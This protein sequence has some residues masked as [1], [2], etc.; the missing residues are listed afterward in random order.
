MWVLGAF[1]GLIGGMLLEDAGAI[2]GLISIGI[3]LI[4]GEELNNIFNLIPPSCK[5]LE[6]ENIRNILFDPEKLDKTLKACDSLKK[7]SREI[8]ERKEKEEKRKKEEE[9]K[10]KKEEEE[11]RKREEEEKRKKE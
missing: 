10:R 11:K 3:L 5:I 9:E 8:K 4:K 1:G 2:I 6:N 7:K